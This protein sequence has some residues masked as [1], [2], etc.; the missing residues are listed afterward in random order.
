MIDV[1]NVSFPY[2]INSLYTLNTNIQFFILHEKSL[3]AKIKKRKLLMSVMVI[4]F[5][6]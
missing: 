4:V 5:L 3:F 2:N 1:F 6:G